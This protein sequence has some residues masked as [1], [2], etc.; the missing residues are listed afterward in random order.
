MD[1]RDLNIPI[2]H[3]LLEVSFPLKLSIFTSKQVPRK[4][5]SLVLF[6]SSNPHLPCPAGTSSQALCQHCQLYRCQTKP[7]PPTRSL[8]F[9]LNSLLPWGPCNLPNNTV[10]T[11]RLCLC[12]PL[13]LNSWSNQWPLMC[14]SP[15]CNASGI[16]IAENSSG[17]GAAAAAAASV[18]RS[19]AH[20]RLWGEPISIPCRV[21]HGLSD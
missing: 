11:G 3:N 17:G 20:G 1:F 4:P 16:N 12:S 13:F 7:I 19:R 18:F 8:L 21:A 14:P 9:P 6:W 10:L 2:N 15:P 5:T